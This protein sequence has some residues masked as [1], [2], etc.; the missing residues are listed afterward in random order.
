MS[1]FSVHFQ[2]RGISRKIEWQNDFL[3]EDLK[4]LLENEFDISN[5][6]LM[7]NDLT[8]KT[9]YKIED[10]F[11]LKHVFNGKTLEITDYDFKE[12]FSTQLL[13]NILNNISINGPWIVIYDE[14][15]QEKV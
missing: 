9:M 7:F 13:E 1:D 8:T 14:E 10:F 11:R 12:E 5:K 4:F 6:E 3:I 2:Y 15:R